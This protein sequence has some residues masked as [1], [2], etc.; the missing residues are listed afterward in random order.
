MASL[1][2]E[3]ESY[4]LEKMQFHRNSYRRASPL[5]LVAATIVA[6]LKWLWP[7]P[8]VTES[9]T[10]QMAQKNFAWEDVCEMVPCLLALH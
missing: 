6:Y 7:L 4:K 5:L 8:Y 9:A 2:V 10:A 3:K 1:A